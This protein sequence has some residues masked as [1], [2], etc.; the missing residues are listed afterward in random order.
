[1]EMRHLYVTFPIDLLR[2]IDELAGPRGRS[3]FV[4][5]AMRARIEWEKLRASQPSV[6][7]ES[8]KAK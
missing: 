2:E 7:E 5:E 6:E 8:M 1:M 3:K 4:V